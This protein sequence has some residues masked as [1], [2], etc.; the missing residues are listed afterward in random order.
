MT[1]NEK[2]YNEIYLTKISKFVKLYIYNI[3][4]ICHALYLMHYFKLKMFF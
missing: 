2:H 3:T 4:Y 1:E